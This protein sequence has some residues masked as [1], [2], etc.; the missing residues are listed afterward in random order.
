MTAA[1]LRTLE[2]AAQLE[3]ATTQ[4][5]L[6]LADR[7][8]EQAR[9]ADALRLYFFRHNLSTLPRGQQNLGGVEFDVRGAIQLTWGGFASRTLQYPDAV[10]GIPVGLPC[11]R[12]QGQGQRRPA[13]ESPVAN[14]GKV[15]SSE[16]AGTSHSAVDSF[17]SNRRTSSNLSKSRSN[18]ATDRPL[19]APT[20][21]R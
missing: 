7:L 2:A 9:A 3:T 6:A 14:P 4:L 1:A 16:G 12:L 15:P 19:S 17:G 20:A 8:D 5:L 10:R 11:R 21:A 13:L 18:E